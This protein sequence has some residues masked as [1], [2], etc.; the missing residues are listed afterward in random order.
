MVW[1]SLVAVVAAAATPLQAPA[2]V[3]G[4]GPAAL[5]L[6]QSWVFVYAVPLAHSYEHSQV[7]ATQCFLSVEGVPLC[8]RG[9][10]HLPAG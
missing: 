5:V 2:E 9:C 10:L 1:T 4:A 8:M 7:C 6:V 3:Q